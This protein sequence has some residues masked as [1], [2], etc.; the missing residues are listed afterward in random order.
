MVR[1]SED[2]LMPRRRPEQRRKSLFPATGASR[3]VLDVLQAATGYV[4]LFTYCD[5]VYNTYI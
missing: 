1:A 2:G 3:P 5:V 4:H